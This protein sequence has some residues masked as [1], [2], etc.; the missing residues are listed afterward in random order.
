MGAVKSID[1]P[2]ELREWWKMFQKAAYRHDYSRV[3]H[4]FVT[5]TL[6]QFGECPTFTQWHAEAMKPYSVEEKTHFNA[7]YFELF[8]VFNEQITKGK[9]Y[10]DA[11]GRIYET[12]NSSGKAS[13]LGQFFT[14]ESACEVTVNVTLSDLTEKDVNKRVL[15]PAC[16]SGR[17]LYVAHCQ[18]PYLLYYGI[19]I[20]TLCAKMSSLNLMM[21]GAVGE[22]VCGNGLWLQKDFS[23]CIKIN[24][25]L[26]HHGI[27]SVMMVEK[28]VSF[29][30]LQDKA[31]MESYKNQ[32]A[33][34]S[35]PAKAKKKGKQ[36]K[37]E[38]PPAPP[39]EPG[40]QL[41]LF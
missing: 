8:R 22:V 35:L 38:V 2:P 10:Y 33:P 23:Y 39:D 31:L 29:I 13:A 1:F 28:D 32:P 5:M 6:T 40:Q 14:P 21:H 30:Y 17:L 7:M 37:A 34:Y 3:F 20:D 26:R 41:I 11:F 15:D 18:H 25:I 12:L 36:P 4:D 19:D 9:P 27:P 24:P 16:G